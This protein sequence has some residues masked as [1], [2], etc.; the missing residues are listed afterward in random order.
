MCVPALPSSLLPSRLQCTQVRHVV[1]DPSAFV[2][3]PSMYP[4]S[5]FYPLTIRP[6]LVPHS[7]LNYPARL[8]NPFPGWDDE[9]F[10]LTNVRLWYENAAVR[11]HTSAQQILQKL[12][13]LDETNFM[14]PDDLG[15]KILEIELRGQGRERLER[16]QWNNHL[17]R[18]DRAL[19]D[20]TAR[21][22]TEKYAM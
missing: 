10:S 7:P 18:R 13:D 20:A 21:E 11:G 3:R 14:R 12:N 1:D 6:V 16:W 17:F 2:S 5:S 22:W 8:Q 15:K 19:Y 4:R 9:F